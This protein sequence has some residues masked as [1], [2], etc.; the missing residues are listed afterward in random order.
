MWWGRGWDC[1][2]VSEG[3]LKPPKKMPR[4]LPSGGDEGA[5]AAGMCVGEGERART[6]FLCISL[7]NSCVFSDMSHFKCILACVLYICL[8]K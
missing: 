7:V 8:I 3:T 6:G 4:S 2:S 5:A 1:F